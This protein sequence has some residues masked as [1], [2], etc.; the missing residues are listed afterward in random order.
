MADRV[1]P[2]KNERT[3]SGEGSEDDFGFPTQAN[4]QE[5]ELACAGI[6][7]GEAGKDGSDLLVR[8]YRE[9]DKWFFEDV[10]NTGGNRKS[11][12]DLAAVGSGINKNQH[13]ALRSL[14][15]FIDS[16][17]ADGFASGAYKEI[18]GQPFPTSIIWYESNAKAQKI[19]EKTITRPTVVTPT[20]I[21]WKMY[22]E[23]GTTV[24]V[25]VQDDIVYSGIFE[26]NRTRTIS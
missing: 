23:D 8:L 18:V 16:G 26:V 9:N 19:V 15:H 24:L 14:I 7:A 13:D 25:T 6:V 17:P 5:D 3:G 10:D 20:P 12:T 4:P 1:R 22:D 2:L 11:L 21:V